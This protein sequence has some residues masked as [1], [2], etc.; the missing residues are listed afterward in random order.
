MKRQLARN[1]AGAILIAL[2]AFFLGLRMN[3]HPENQKPGNFPE[4]LVFVR[5]TDDVVNG[6]VLFTSTSAHA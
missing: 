4:Q 2:A 6:V 5:S 3:L 1:A